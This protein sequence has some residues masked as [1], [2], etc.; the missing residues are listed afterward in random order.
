MLE[1]ADEFVVTASDGL[2]DYYSPDSS[3]VSD[4]R[5]TLRS[6]GND[7]QACAEW[8]VR[9]ALA[10]QRSTLHA[11]TPGDNVTVVVIS[12]RPLTAIPRTS[13][14]RLNLRSASSFDLASPKATPGAAEGGAAEHPASGQGRI[15]GNGSAGAPG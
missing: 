11:G 2:W 6:G 13:A 10:R 3:V 14:S 15:Q 4:A 9:Q 7:A 12:L 8:L 5:R 1:E